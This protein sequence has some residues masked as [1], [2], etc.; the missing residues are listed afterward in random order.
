[1]KVSSQPG[2]V[3]HA[4]NPNTWEAEE[5]GFLSSKASLDYRVHSRTAKAIQRNPVSKKQEKK[6]SQ[7]SANSFY[8]TKNFTSNHYQELLHIF[9][10]TYSIN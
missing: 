10:S 4:F 2:V 1:M 6:E 9:F 8:C 7:L 3:A 5:G